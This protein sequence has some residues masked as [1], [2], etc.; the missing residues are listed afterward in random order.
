MTPDLELIPYPCN[1]LPQRLLEA[2]RIMIEAEY[3]V[4]LVG[5]A[6][7]NLV[8]KRPPSDFDLAT[9]AHPH[10]ITTLFRRVIPTGIA[11]GTVTVLYRGLSLE[12]TTFR[13]EGAYSDGRRPDEVTFGTS[14]VE[15]LSR[16]DFTMNA[17]AIDIKHQVLIDPYGGRHD[18]DQH[19]VRAVGDPAS[20][21]S[22]DALR[23]LRAVRFSVQLEFA[24]APN[25][26]VA[27]ASAAPKLSAISVERVRIELEKMLV[28]EQP[29][30]AFRI[31][32]DQGILAHILPEF[33]HCITAPTGDDA[34]GLSLYEHLIRSMDAT[35]SDRLELRLA[36]LLHDIGKPNT[37]IR[38]TDGTMRFIG[39][40]KESARISSELLK[41]LCFPTRVIRQVE[42]LVL[43]HMFF[44][45][46]SWSP[47]AVRRFIARV[48]KDNVADLV[49]L[50][51][52]DTLGK[53]GNE[54]ASPLLN[55]LL[56]RVEHENQSAGAFTIRDLAIGG[57]DL[58][59]IG[60]KKGP[61]MGK[62]L[63]ELL[64]TV[65]DDPDLNTKPR[66]LQIA[67]RLYETRF[68]PLVRK[69]QE[70]D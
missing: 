25:T 33:L 40:E 48:G 12:V 16:R 6:V 7:R 34:P 59:S 62:I 18:I 69:G 20:R 61:E 56:Q 51:R 60:V 38:D 28:S 54:K 24:L 43:H 19:Q 50:R 8:M 44:Y 58:A 3:Q 35:P 31:F 9:D 37:Q 47:A 1:R 14:I 42:H 67:Q 36:A 4:Y 26:L 57:N 10:Q 68:Q 45:E 39:H 15:D 66:L 23:I 11:H 46:P 49:L 5:G 17:M 55:E 63:E 13:S 22:E 30:R 64:E 2:C 52:A 65:L 41:R 29:S 32:R 21:L 70:P 53:H 27:L